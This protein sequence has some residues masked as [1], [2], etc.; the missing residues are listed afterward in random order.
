VPSDLNQWAVT[1]DISGYDAVHLF[2]KT[3]FSTGWFPE[4]I[5]SGNNA[6]ITLIKKSTRAT[7]YIPVPVQLK[8]VPYLKG[9]E[10]STAALTATPNNHSVART[11]A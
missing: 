1:W 7:A 11:V 2:S 9:I 3:Q 4:G 5:F 10:Y 8:A 6:T